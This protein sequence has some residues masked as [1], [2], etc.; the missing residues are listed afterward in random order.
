MLVK[1]QLLDIPSKESEAFSATV[2]VFQVNLAELS[3]RSGAQKGEIERLKSGSTHLTSRT[4]ARIL[5][6]LNPEERSFYASMVAI[7][8]AAEDAKLKMP[9]L[10]FPKLDG[11]SD[12]FRQAFA[13]TTDIFGIEDLHV[14]KNSGIADS[15]LNAW[16][17]GNRDCELRT[18]D[19]IKSA[20]TPHQR[21]F[22]QAISDVLFILSASTKAAT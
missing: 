6:G 18:L 14:A 12:V 3:R 19:K 21:T 11:S 16:K 7:Q 20:L 15:N 22:F 9:I 1:Q 4:L 8:W 13:M 17:K 5:G 10:N 2:A